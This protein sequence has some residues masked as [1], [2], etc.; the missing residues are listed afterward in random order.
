MPGGIDREVV[1]RLAPEPITEK[2]KE[3]IKGIDATELGIF[4]HRLEMIASECKEMLLKLGASTGCRWGDIGFGIYTSS[5]DNAMA[6]T[7]IYFHTI[8]G[9]IP[10]KYI[11]K[12][13]ADDPSVGIKP[14]DA[15]FC[16]DPLYGGVH[17]CDMGVWTPIFY[18]DELVCWAGSVI[19]TGENG[20]TEPG[21][22]PTQS[23]SRYD[24]GLLIPPIKICEN[25]LLKEDFMNMVCH[26]IRDPRSF[27]LDIKARLA[28]CRLGERRIVELVT[29]KGAN[30]VIGAI[31]SLIETTANAARM[32]LRQYNDGVFRVARF[33]DAVGTEDGLMKTTITMEKRGDS[34][35]FDFT[36][37]S[38]EVRDHPCNTHWIGVLGVCCIYFCGY[39]FPDLPSNAG[40]LAP[41]QWKVPENTYINPSMESPTG[42]SP[43]AQTNSEIGMAQLGAKLIFSQDPD[44]SVA[45]GWCAFNM[46]YFGGLNQWGEPVAD[47]TADINGAGYGASRD[48][49]GISVG[50]AVF[51]PESDTGDAESGELYLPWLYLFRGFL[52]SSFGHGKFR[53]GAGMNYAMVV[54]NVPWVFLGG[55]GFGSKFPALYGLFGGYA[56]PTIPFTRIRQSNL[57]ELL[58]KSDPNTPSS[59][60]MLYEG[61]AIKGSYTVDSYPS[62]V[63]PMVDGDMIVGSMGGGA[64]YGDTIERD[65]RLVMQDLEGGLIS[66]WVARNVYKVVYDE[67][68]L[69]VDEEKTKLRREQEMADRKRRGLK[70]EEF[71]REWLK[72]KPKD[73]V[74]KFYGNWPHPSQQ[75]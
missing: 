52:P 54:H 74:L 45:P 32:R 35:F 68:T 48:R 42:L 11:I 65:P 14:G 34:L 17:G 66:H 53:G 20:S 5:G 43:F 70:Y 13:W 24:E 28:A 22:S 71:E 59:A 55:L 47:V 18:E 33:T 31:R 36:D 75:E 38:P 72:I 39:L 61:K 46:P 15:F 16:N 9:Q 7:G 21:G 58:E 56:P 27:T 64:S 3:C 1:T 67:D 37:T 60:R 2:E 30:F 26:M 73:E 62:V 69:I 44:R 63:Q 19:H 8:L 29:E 49:D 4:T 57:K 25:Y 10:L 51:A 12:H 23:R 40:L 50:G 41:L 6:S